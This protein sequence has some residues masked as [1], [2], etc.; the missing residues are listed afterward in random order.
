MALAQL[1]EKKKTVQTL[2][3]TT[4]SQSTVDEPSTTIICQ[5]DWDLISPRNIEQ[6][7]RSHLR[8]T[9]G[10]GIGIGI[11]I[12]LPSAAISHRP[13]GRLTQKEKLLPPCLKVVFRLVV[14]SLP[15]TQGLQIQPT[16]RL[17][18]SLRFSSHPSLSHISLP[19][20][21]PY[22]PDET[23]YLFHFSVSPTQLLYG[24]STLQLLFIAPKQFGS[25]S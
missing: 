7:Q 14:C 25:A 19:I 9:H 13:Q 12:L 2:I 11:G 16:A 8:C 23:L 17:S 6:Q 22:A 20:F 18:F 3:T 4:P 5:A 1:K 10:I 21:V 15:Q 24:F